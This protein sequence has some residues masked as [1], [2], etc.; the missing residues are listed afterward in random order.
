MYFFSVIIPLYN[1]ENYIEKTLKSVLNQNFTD[2]EII[3]IDDC[4]TDNS[5][6]KIIDY[7]DSRIRIIKKSKNSG[8]SATRN[9]GIQNSTCDYI[10]FIDADDLWEP[11]FLDEIFKLIKMYPEAS[12]YGTNYQEITAKGKPID[13]IIPDFLYNEDRKL[14]PNFFSLNISQPM[15]CY[16]TVAFHKNVFE[17]AGYFDENITFAEDIDFN[18]RVNLTNKLAYSSKVC[19]SYLLSS[20]NQITSSMISNKIIPDLDKYQSL[21]TEQNGLE[22]YLDFNRYVFAMHYKTEG[23]KVKFKEIKRRINYKNI[24]IKQV[25]LLKLPLFIVFLIRRFKSFLIRYNIKISSY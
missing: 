3:I 14:I 22:K 10:T 2:F 4:S 8:L 6:S 20:E 18:I 12:I 24:T 25:I 16:T 19:A 9:T 11:F 17:N 23:N 5:L 13:I 1:K 15:Y 21:S 7:S